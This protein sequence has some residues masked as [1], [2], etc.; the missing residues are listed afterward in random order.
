M[1][2]SHQRHF[3]LFRVSPF[4]KSFLAFLLGF[5]IASPKIARLAPENMN[6][7]ERLAISQIAADLS[8]SGLRAETEKDRKEAMVRKFEET[9]ARFRWGKDGGPEWE[10]EPEP[11]AAAPPETT[12]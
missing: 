4:L 6:F 10:K 8:G 9:A 12:P 5:M 11:E 1:T 2:N 3:V 7:R